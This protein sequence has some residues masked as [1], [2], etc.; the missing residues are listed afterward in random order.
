MY[1]CHT[2]ERFFCCPSALLSYKEGKHWQLRIDNVIS[3]KVWL[4]TEHIWSYHVKKYRQEEIGD[5]IYT[6]VA[7]LNE[8]HEMLANA[9][10]RKHS[11][12]I[13]D[14][15]QFDLDE[16]LE[17]EIL[18]LSDT[19]IPETDEERFPIVNGVQSMEIDENIP[20]EEKLLLSPVSDKRMH[21]LQA[22]L[23]FQ[24]V[25]SKAYEKE[26]ASLRAEVAH[27][28]INLD[29]FCILKINNN[30]LY[31]YI[32][33]VVDNNIHFYHKNLF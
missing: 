11:V 30:L 21:I 5:V 17:D 16:V 27:M 8:N 4:G 9:H 1:F 22:R 15:V 6:K 32:Y 25:K 28:K 12:R 18:P 23:E 29:L 7:K 10:P 31:I 3:S 13:Y 14:N 19:T 33:L 26:N 24:M 2:C 20:V